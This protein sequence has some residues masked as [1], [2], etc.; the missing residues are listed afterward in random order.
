MRCLC[1]LVHGGHEIGSTLETAPP[2]TRH[3]YPCLSSAAISGSVSAAA[4]FGSQSQKGQSG[5][6]RA[7]R[8]TCEARRAGG[9]DSPNAAERA[10][11]TLPYLLPLLDGLR[12]SAPPFLSCSARPLPTHAPAPP[13]PPPPIARA[14]T[15]FLLVNIP[16]VPCARRSLTSSHPNATNSHRQV[17]LPR[18]PA[19]ESRPSPAAAAHPGA[20]E[21]GSRYRCSIRCRSAPLC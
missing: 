15:R 12:Y 2:L 18:V 9:D 6:D 7:T 19:A 11:S 8:L 20:L 10:V 17:L 1:F 13:R 16:H 5:R 4:A 21:P 3:L 14:R